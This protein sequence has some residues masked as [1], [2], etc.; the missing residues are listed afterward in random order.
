MRRRVFS[1][2]GPL[3]F[4]TLDTVATDTFASR[5]TSLI[6]TMILAK[7]PGLVPLEGGPR[8][9]AGCRVIG[10]SQSGT[11]KI[12]NRLHRGRQRGLFGGCCRLRSLPTHH[13]DVELSRVRIQ[14][15]PAVPKKAV[16]KT[17]VSSAR[18]VGATALFFGLA[19]C[20]QVAPAFGPNI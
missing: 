4:R 7:G 14:A 10:Q 11:P 8:S 3:S 5:A 1:L 20:R 2:T 13:P 6:V 15:W 18:F 9:A 19:A 12:C 17:S 16:A